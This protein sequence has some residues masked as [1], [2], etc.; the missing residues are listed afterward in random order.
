MTTPPS[1][2]LTYEALLAVAPQLADEPLETVSG[3][4]FTV[5]VLRDELAFTPMS[6]GWAQ[7]D[8][9]TAHRRFVARFNETGSLRP[10]D[11]GKVSRNASYLIGLIVAARA[12]GLIR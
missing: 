11:Y 4:L 3:R 8:G 12:R 10:A 5:Q 6:S 1:S 2:T 9:R 7:T